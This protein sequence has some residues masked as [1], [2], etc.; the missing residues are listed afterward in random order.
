MSKL[1][2][3]M[4]PVKIILKLFDCCIASIL[5]GSEVWA[6]FMNLDWKQWHTAHIEK[7]HTQFL[8]RLL[9]VN[10]ST[11][12]VLIRSEVGKHSLQEQ[13]L[14][15]NI[16]YIKY[17]ENKGPPSLV[18][19]EYEHN[20]VNRN[21]SNEIRKLSKPKLCNIIK[22]EFNTWQTQATTFTKADTYTI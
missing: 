22:E 19:Q 1:P 12:N 10:R 13:I 3:N 17:I 7:I 6:P 11:T 4:T 5:Y 14:A 20:L 16:N 8:K 2:F 21:N 15:R 9:G 18:K